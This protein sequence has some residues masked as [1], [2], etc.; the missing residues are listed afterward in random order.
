MD[1]FVVSRELLPFVHKL[2]IDNQRK[3]TPAI[4]VKE[5]ENYKFI[6]TDHSSL[7]LT[8]KDLP[9]EQKNKEKTKTLWNLAKENGWNE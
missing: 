9:R 2:E 3:M 7:L 5:K 6:F 1:L 8:I 4:A